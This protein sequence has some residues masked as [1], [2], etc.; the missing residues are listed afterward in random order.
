MSTVRTFFSQA[1]GA[2]KPWVL[3]FVRAFGR[4]SDRLYPGDK[5]VSRRVRVLTS[6]LVA[7]MMSV[8][9]GLILV[10]LVFR[11]YSS[12]LPSTDQLADYSPPVV[13]R[14]YT[15]NSKLLAEYATEKRF[16]V[17]FSAI[18]E[19]LK[20]AFISAEDRNFYSHQGVDLWGITRAMMHNIANIG[21]D[22][23]MMGGSTI[24]QQVVKNFLLTSEK[25][26]ERKVKEAILA[27]RISGLYSKQKILELY[28]NQIYLGRGTYGVAAAAVNFFNKS[29][30]ELTIEE[31][32]M[33]AA[34]PK[35]P[36]YYDPAQNYDQALARRNYVIERMRE[37]GAISDDEAAAAT[38]TAILLRAKP[39]TEVARADFFA[40]EVRRQLRKMYG[41]NVL[42]EGGLYVKTTVDPAMQD[43]ADRALRYALRLY[44]ERHGYRGPLAN[45]KNDVVKWQPALQALQDTRKFPLYDAEALAI[46]LQVDASTAQI[47]VL[48]KGRGSMNLEA[49]RW[50]RKQLSDTRVGNAISKV[51]DVLAVGDVVLVNPVEKGKS[52]YTLLQIPAV[53]GA[54]VVMDPHNGKVLAMSGGYSY[55]GSE[56]N[57][58]T[59]AKRQPGSAFKPFVYLAALE[60]GF[61]WTQP[62]KFR[63][64]LVCLCGD[65]RIMKASF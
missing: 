1:I 54:M 23:S 40:E 7:G 48:D 62:L 39:T 5:P 55:G 42:Y 21:S 26:L 56:F 49:V 58:A 28:L 15:S 32:A 44:D 2:A 37:D 41:F 57:R 14:L 46:V 47:G 17:P 64:G 18:P 63:K 20:Q 61:L 16:F 27:Y 36:A 33:L 19:R 11:H 45:L 22:Q 13:T 34:M 12:D 53:N 6:L 3:G 29:L 35:A 60:N 4:F 24:T 65:Q 9:A 52:A 51:G 8:I 10:M 25:S 43:H 30:D 50:A 59:Q 38:K 31:A